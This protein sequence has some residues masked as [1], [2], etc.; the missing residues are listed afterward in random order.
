[1]NALR[2]DLDVRTAT[3]KALAAARKAKDKATPALAVLDIFK[4]GEFRYQVVRIEG[5]N[6]H[7]RA[8]SAINKF[9]GP[10]ET[11]LALGK[12]RVLFPTF[13]G[14]ANVATRLL[15]RCFVL[16][17]GAGRKAPFLQERGAA[18]S[19]SG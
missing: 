6:V 13:Q 10:V 9:V 16:Q 3:C 5:N 11:G 12:T 17:T 1:M 14:K 4:C 7:A 18:T 15:T 8:I 2:S 19:V